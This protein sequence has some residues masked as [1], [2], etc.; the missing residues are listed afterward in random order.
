MSDN[1]FMYSMNSSELRKETQKINKNYR[2]NLAVNRL[3]NKAFKSRTCN[4]P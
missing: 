1:Q 2:L 4:K 3:L